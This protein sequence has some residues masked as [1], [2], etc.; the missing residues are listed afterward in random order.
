MLERRNQYQVWA[1]EGNVL[2]PESPHCLFAMRALR[3]PQGLSWPLGFS[4]LS[5]GA[6]VGVLHD[7]HDLGHL[8]SAERPVVAE[9]HRHASDGGLIALDDVLGLEHDDVP[10]YFL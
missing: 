6:A 2:H 7:P 10:E 5:D 1:V 4:D 3:M 9:G 8:E